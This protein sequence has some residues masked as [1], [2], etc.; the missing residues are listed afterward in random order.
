[1]VAVSAIDSLVP[2]GKLKLNVILSPS[3]G[4]T[5]PRSIVAAGGEPVGCVT[6][7]PVKDELIEPSFNPNDEP[8]S[9][10]RVTVVVGGGDDTVRCPI[11]PTP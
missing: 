8:S 7:A 1:M 5:A 11:L 6:V 3:L 9:E 10:T 2:S 4:L